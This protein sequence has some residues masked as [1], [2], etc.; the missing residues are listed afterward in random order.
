[1]LDEINAVRISQVD[2]LLLRTDRTLE[3]IAIECGFRSVPYMRTL[4]Q[5]V[6][7]ESL[8]ERRNGRRV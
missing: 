7:G 2:Y 8:G 4:F 5:R 6:M 3:S 1:M